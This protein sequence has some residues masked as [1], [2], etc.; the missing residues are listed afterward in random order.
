MESFTG[1]YTKMIEATVTTLLS[2]HL[3]TGASN[4]LQ[5]F[6]LPAS[7]FKEVKKLLI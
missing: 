6:I 2:A 1:S 7:F 3:T 4:V 5:T